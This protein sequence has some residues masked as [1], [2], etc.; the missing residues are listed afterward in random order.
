[1]RLPELA[2]LVVLSIAAGRWSQSEAA[3]PASLV[4]AAYPALTA[5]QMHAGCLAQGQAGAGAGAGA[6][7]LEGTGG[8]SGSY[9][10]M[11]ALATLAV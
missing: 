2:A 7:Q 9:R 5:V 6:Q 10:L 3:R 11:H 8:R 4:V 1:M